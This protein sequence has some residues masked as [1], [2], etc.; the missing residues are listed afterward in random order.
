VVLGL[1]VLGGGVLLPEL[2]GRVGIIAVRADLVVSGARLHDL[3]D[4]SLDFSLDF[5]LCFA[6]CF[7]L[8][9]D[10]ARLLGGLGTRGGDD[11]VGRGRPVRHRYVGHARAL[12]GRLQRL[13]GEHGIDDGLCRGGGHGLELCHLLGLDHVFGLDHSVRLDRRYG[14]ARGLSLVLQPTAVGAVALAVAV[15]VV[16]AAFGAGLGLGLRTLGGEAGRR[17]RRVHIRVLGLGGL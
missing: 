14:R 10:S 5:A 7:A 12:G 4:L 15:A 11:G 8:G 9:R 2:V 13:V 6:L 16:A 1:T 17:R 3:G